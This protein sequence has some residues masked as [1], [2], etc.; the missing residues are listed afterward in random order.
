MHL[1]NSIPIPDIETTVQFYIPYYSRGIELKCPKLND[2]KVK[3]NLILI[4]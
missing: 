1:I 4:L 3:P 2:L